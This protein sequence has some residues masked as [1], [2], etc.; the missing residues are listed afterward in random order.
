MT[1]KKSYKSVTGLVNSTAKAFFVLN[2]FTGRNIILVTEYERELENIYDSFLG[3]KEIYETKYNFETIYL[4]EEK[5]NFLSS[6]ATLSKPSRTPR[7]ILATTK[8]LN[9]KIPHI[10]H[11]RKKLFEIASGKSI[12]RNILTKKLSELG[13]TKVDFVEQ[14]AEYALRGTVVDIFT[15]KAEKPIRVYFSADEIISIKTFDI[16]TQNTIKQINKLLVMPI[17]LE[18]TRQKL[19][20]WL[21]KDFVFISDE[22]ITE[23]TTTPPGAIRFTSHHAD[24]KPLDYDANI[25]FFADIN[26]L[27]REVLRFSRLAIRPIISSLN[28]GELNRLKQLCENT[29]IPALC[30][31]KISRLVNGFFHLSGRTSI[32]TSS[33]IFGRI[34]QTSKS[35][36]KIASAD[37]KRVHYKELATGDYVVHE[38]YGIAKYNGIKTLISSNEKETSTDCLEL[39]FRFNHKLFVP[40]YDF[41]KVQKFIS[42]K[43]KPTRLSALGKST[44]AN[45]KE[46]IK[47]KTKIVAEEILKLEAKRFSAKAFALTGDQHIEREF[48]DSFPY[49][50]TP[51]Q[52]KA[53]QE[54]LSDL[55]GVNPTE[56][57]L[58]GD[59]GFGKTEIAI[60]ASLRAALGGKQ[61]LVLV[62]T[63]ILAAQH[64]QTFTKRLA[65]FPVKTEMLCRF[66]S[67]SEQK[68]IVADAASGACDII[69]GTHRLLSKDIKIKN[70]GLVIIDEEHRFGVRQKEKIKALSAKT[71]CLL[72]SATPI[73]RTLNQA[74]SSLKNISIIETPPRGR[75]PITTKVSPWDE[76]TALSAIEAELRRGGQ[77]FYVHNRVKTLQNRYEFLANKMPEARI[78]VGHGQMQ[79][80]KLEKT[81]WDFYSRKY[82]ILLASTIIESG[83]D[84]PDVNTMIVENANEFGLAQLYQL[85]GRIGR[86]DKKAYCWLFYPQK[87]AETPQPETRRFE[88][89][90]YARYR[91]KKSLQ[92]QTSNAFERLSALREFSSLGSGFRLALRDLEIRGAGELIG[93]RQH[94]FVRA[95]GLYLYTQLLTSEI[96]KSKGRKE[97]ITEDTIFETDVSAYIPADYLPDETERLNYYKKLINSGYEKS[98]KIL[99]ELKDLCGYLPTEV[100]NI[101]EI[102]NIRKKAAASGIRRIIHSKDSFEFYMA[103]TPAKE[104]ILKLMAE[105]KGDISFKK[106]PAGDA[107]KI[108]RKTKN[109][110]KFIYKIIELMI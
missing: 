99:D 37:A 25:K 91:R 108:T 14:P 68:K 93:T 105:Y 54:T 110:F 18:H 48:A 86:S 38:D 6:L 13:Y 34:Y 57:I 27:E 82:D 53:I 103:K 59:V 106:T 101:S 85:R 45:I 47:E 63:T 39:S 55:A 51:D 24:E 98:G 33:D 44:W 65:S 69:I 52:Q 19:T 29:K 61:T 20:D 9:E 84:L 43:A 66:Q 32:I 95:V 8:S 50:E 12:K 42:T 102:I 15:P 67:K 26:L 90:F 1:T 49:E 31:F 23:K 41:Q 40:F 89:D 80:G 30:D 78:C 104:A 77:V 73:P 16:E 11:Y 35:L 83:L 74:L 71:H 60:R 100:K 28:L 22:T 79:S 109:P 72:L 75:M 7:I 87:L 36:E 88:L 96:E 94:G 70:L 107:L 21:A 81:M 3:L 4:G 5:N 46:R 58:A 62:P 56:R 2:E 64:Y 76:K 97:I 10:S 17:R 92:K